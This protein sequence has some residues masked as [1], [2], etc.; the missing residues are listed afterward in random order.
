M[1]AK[2]FKILGIFLSVVILTGFMISCKSSHQVC[3]AY[4]KIDNEVVKDF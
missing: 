3:P 4:T 1:Q 2:L